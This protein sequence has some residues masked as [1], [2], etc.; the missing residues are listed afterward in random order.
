MTLYC[1]DVENVQNYWGYLLTKTSPGDKVILFFTEICRP[2]PL[3]FLA[4]IIHHGIL[5]DAI[6]CHPGDE[7]HDN[8]LDFQLCTELGALIHGNAADEYVIIS[9]DKGFDAVVSYW[10]NKGIKISRFAILSTNP[11]KAQKRANAAK[12]DHKSQV[13]HKTGAMGKSECIDY[14]KSCLQTAGIS[15]SKAGD[16]AVLMA[17]AMTMPMNK[18][19]SGLYHGIIAKFG[20]KHGRNLYNTAKTVFQDVSANGPRPVDGK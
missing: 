6:S 4:N 11:V 14:Y 7:R 20:K 2:M 16:I 10:S 3:D 1:I 13:P 17:D 9:E 12:T 19:L 15:S 18:R 5:L 8:A